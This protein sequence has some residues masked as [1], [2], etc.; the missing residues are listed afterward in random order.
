[1]RSPISVAGHTQT[2][3]TNPVRLG[4]DRCLMLAEALPVPNVT[5]TDEGRVEIWNPRPEVVLTR[6]SGRMAMK[7]AAP[8]MQAVEAA[9]AACPGQVIV[10][11]DWTGI[12]SYEVEVQ[13]RMSAW[14][15]RQISQIERVVIG[16]DSPLVALA[17]RTANLAVGDRFEIVRSREEVE[18]AI[19]S[20]LG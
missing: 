20:A 12:A 18:Q 10:F 11:H 19:R 7:H 17:V 3:R 15:L 14:S 9:I 13:A 4:Y 16:V 5:E 8:I 2:L 1:M 6:A